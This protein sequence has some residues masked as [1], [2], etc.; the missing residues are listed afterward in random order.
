MYVLYD[1]G[2][3]NLE[4]LWVKKGM[5]MVDWIIEDSI[6]EGEEMGGLFVGIV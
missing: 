2:C 3:E 1:N 5:E 6:E 4:L